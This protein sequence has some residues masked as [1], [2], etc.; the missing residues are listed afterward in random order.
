MLNKAIEIATCAHTGQVDKAGAP[1]IL[2][3]L[4][5]MLTRDNEIERI[6]AILH[7]VIEDTD[8]TFADLRNEGFSEE[9]ITVLDCLTKRDGEAYDDFIDRVLINETAC[10]VKLADLCDN[11]DLS[12]IENPTEKD[13]ERLEKYKKASDRIFDAIPMSEGIKNERLIR[14]EGCVSIQPFLSHD[15]FLNR[16]ITFVEINGW[17]FGGGTEDVTDQKE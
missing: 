8:I 2:H 4:R 16:F 11:M 3:P 5:V 13:K 14:I 9:V 15:D 12:R 17:Y 10:R 1:Y 6:C 7:D